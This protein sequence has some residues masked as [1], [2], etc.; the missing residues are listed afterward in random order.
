[1]YKLDLILICTTNTTVSKTTKYLKLDIS[2]FI[3]Y[4]KKKISIIVAVFVHAMLNLTMIYK[5]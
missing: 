2:R 3:L 5:K 4:L 1:M